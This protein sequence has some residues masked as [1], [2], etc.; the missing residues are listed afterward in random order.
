LHLQSL[1]VSNGCHSR[2]G[3]YCLGFP[4]AMKQ[5][6]GMFLYA[7][8]LNKEAKV[9]VTTVTGMDNNGVNF[10]NVNVPMLTSQNCSTCQFYNIGSCYNLFILEQFTRNRTRPSMHLAGVILFQNLCLSLMGKFIII[11][12]IN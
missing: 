12:K 10:A 1:A 6:V 5:Q 3:S 8:G 2:V 4:S 11:N 9:S 7:T